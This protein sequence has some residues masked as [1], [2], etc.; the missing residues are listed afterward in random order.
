MLEEF[1]RNANEELYSRENYNPFQL[2][3][4]ILH[5]AM[6]AGDSEGID[7]ALVGVKEDRASVKN[8]GCALAPD[9]IRKQLFALSKPN[10][11]I[12]I[13]D[14]GNIE[15]GETIRDTYIALSRVVNEL[16]RMRIIPVI[17]GGSHDLT[18]GQFGAYYDLNRMINIS[19]ID[20]MIDLKEDHHDIDDESFLM[21]IFQY[22]PSFIFNVNLV[23]Y[24]THLTSQHAIEI[25][26][27]LNFESYRL[28]KVKMDLNEMEPVLRDT[29]LFSLDM[30]AIRY[31]D[32][33]G[34]RNTTPNGLFAEEVCQLARFA[35]QSDQ[36]DSFGIYGCNPT[37]DVRDQSVQL[38]ADIIW[39]FIDGFYNRKNDFPKHEEPDYMKYTIQFKENKYEMNFWKSK[40]TDHWWMEV[41][42]GGELRNRKKSFMIPCSYTDYQTALREEVPERWIKAYQKLS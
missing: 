27:H 36:V 26:N 14:A 30:S 13:S 35:G 6:V 19:I 1:L 3:T 40:K 24:Q 41:P 39:Y 20:S 17:I 32:A 31:A 28:G 29:N 23:A 11:E 16:L 7:I 12:K 33:P 15:K 18:F 4:H 25:M 37:V 34:N 22:Q 10:Y 9:E 2:G 42:A 38:A 8:N 21:Q 5:G